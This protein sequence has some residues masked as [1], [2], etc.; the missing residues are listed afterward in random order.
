MEDELTRLQNCSP[1]P[2]GYTPAGES[3]GV[4][5]RSKAIFWRRAKPP[6]RPIL[7]LV[8]AGMNSAYD[9]VCLC[10]SRAQIDVAQ[11]VTDVATMATVATSDALACYSWPMEALLALPTT[12]TDGS[13]RKVCPI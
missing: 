11:V 12:S 8:I 7:N 5:P 9:C 2:R 1:V 4:V 3:V 6:I 10:C 13:S